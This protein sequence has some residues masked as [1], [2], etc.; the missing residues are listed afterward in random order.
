MLCL[1][2]LAVVDL[3][4][5]LV[6]EENFPAYPR[7]LNVYSRAIE[8]ADASENEL[9]YRTLGLDFTTKIL[10]EAPPKNGELG[11]T[12]LKAMDNV[13]RFLEKRGDKNN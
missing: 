2:L 9:D 3:L 7:L 4:K 6:A 10:E 1:K 13:Y 12:I 11:L 5:Q 8:I